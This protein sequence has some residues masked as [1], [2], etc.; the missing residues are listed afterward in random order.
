M[1]G[2]NQIGVQSTTFGAGNYF[3]TGATYWSKTFTGTTIT[4]PSLGVGAE[5]AGVL[6]TEFA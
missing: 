3:V 6:L 5:V 4:I 2:W 1:A